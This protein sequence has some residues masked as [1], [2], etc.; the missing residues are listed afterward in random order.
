METCGLKGQRRSG[1]DQDEEVKQE[2]ASKN[3]VEFIL[4]KQGIGDECGLVPKLVRQGKEFV[5]GEIWWVVR[6]E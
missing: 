1:A 6:G 4:G 2:D 3:R 5:Y